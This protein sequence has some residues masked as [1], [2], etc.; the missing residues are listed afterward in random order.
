M[1]ES[2]T[3]PRFACIKMSW[4]KE[5]NFYIIKKIFKWMHKW[6]CREYIKKN[7]KKDLKW[8]LKG[9]LLLDNVSVTNFFPM[10][11]P[12]LEKKDIL[13]LKKINFG[14]FLWYFHSWQH[15]LS[16]HC[17]WNIHLNTMY[18]YVVVQCNKAYTTHRDM[19]NAFSRICQKNL[20]WNCYLGVGKSI[21]W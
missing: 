20:F 19:W 11:V 12:Q 15:W 3:S 13:Q 5:W 21:F 18:M 2:W 16:L 9:S 4:E 14:L 17:M 7:Y 8:V 10:M 6:N 1:A